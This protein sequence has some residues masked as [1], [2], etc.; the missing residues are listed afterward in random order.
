MVTNAF[1]RKG[2]CNVPPHPPFSLFSYHLSRLFLLAQTHTHIFVKGFL[3]NFPRLCQLVRRM[4]FF[5]LRGYFDVIFSSPR[6]IKMRAC[7]GSIAKYQNDVRINCKQYAIFLFY[8]EKWFKWVFSVARNNVRE[9]LKISG[10]F[11][12]RWEKWDGFLY[13]STQ[14]HENDFEEEK[15]GGRRILRDFHLRWRRT[16]GEWYL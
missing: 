6:L 10:K 13:F 1:S 12:K 5:F 9:I 3:G 2:K 4:V 11:I 8:S 15:M 16:K 14:A 7:L